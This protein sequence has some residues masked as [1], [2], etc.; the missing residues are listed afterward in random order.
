MKD[1]RAWPDKR[2]AMDH[3]AK[4]RAPGDTGDG[5]GAEGSVSPV[6]GTQAWNGQLGANLR[7]LESLVGI[8]HVG[9][10]L[11][12]DA[13]FPVGLGASLW[14]LWRLVVVGLGADAGEWALLFSRSLGTL[15]IS[16]GKVGSYPGPRV[17]CRAVPVRAEPVPTPEKML[18][19]AQ[20]ALLPHL[21]QRESIWRC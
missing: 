7:T 1:H 9:G 3:G 4:A 18:S 5:S 20:G 16:R 21:G 12:P 6:G 13:I 10:T 8:C 11:H 17:P 2:G 19:G 14:A 15:R